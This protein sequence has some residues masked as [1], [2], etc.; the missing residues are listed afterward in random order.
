MP[1]QAK[2]L[3][4]DEWHMQGT[5]NRLDPNARRAA[6]KV[7][8]AAVLRGDK[9]RTNRERRERQHRP[10]AC[11]HRTRADDRCPSTKRNQPRGYACA[12]LNRRYGRIKRDWLTEVRRIL[13]TGNTD[14]RAG[15]VYGVRVAAGCTVR[16]MRVT[17]VLGR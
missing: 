9:M 12:W 10:A 7:R 2:R 8:V 3:A 5:P 4:D 1:T 14:D 11:I 16:V 6:A 13:R 17:R 15:L